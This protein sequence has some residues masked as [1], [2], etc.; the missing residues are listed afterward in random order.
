MKS[1]WKDTFLGE[2]V[3]IKQGLAINAKS[4]HLLVEDGMP[5]LRITDLLNDKQV[6]FINAAEAPA[7]C[8][9]NEEDLIYTRT[10][11]VGHIFRGKVGV[12]HN[13][14]FRIIPKD[15]NI[16]RGYL[17]WFLSQDKIRKYANDISSGSVQKDLSHS[18][19]KSIPIAIP[20]P[21]TQH[22]IE[23]ILNSID[24]KIELNRKMNE[25]LE[26]MAQA[27]F[28]SWFV[29]F[30]PVH[31]KANAKSDAELEKAAAELGISKEVL[32]LFPST[33][34]ESEMGMI[35][36]GWE[37]K[38]LDDVVDFQNGYSFKSKEL[39]EDP[40]NSIKI[41]KMGH[42]Q[43]GGGFKEEG[44]DT[45]FYNSDNPTKM[46]KY[47]LKKGDILMAM[48]DMKANMALLAHTALMP[49]DD[50]Y[51]LNQ[52]VGRLRVKDKHLLDYPYLY[53]FSNH[54]DT[55]HD[56]RSRSNS[57][58]Q[59]NLTTK[60]ILDTKIIVP[61]NQV[62]NEFNKLVS[63]IFAKVFANN[64]EIVNLQKTRDTLLPKLLSGELDVSEV[65]I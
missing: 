24:D 41:F 9:A 32:E 53:I 23:L 47:L 45:Y 22:K 48:T 17:Y 51:L 49:H 7:Q 56:L 30:D 20:S 36:E 64:E 35:P 54:V 57:G 2:L 6:R 50:R 33:F 14:C 60:A 21:N 55:I 27:L 1:E 59:V 52:R 19:F 65:E 44:K 13:N 39:H 18:A 8:I 63:V 10:G 15:E 62:H 31:A 3:D 42:I 34:V 28:K 37:V 26:A 43:R 4:K 25:T 38:T 29:D 12:V 16:T 46:N 5:L 11:Q 58:V 40:H 61:N